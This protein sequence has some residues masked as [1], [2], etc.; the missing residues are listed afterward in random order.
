[1]LKPASELLTSLYAKIHPND[2]KDDVEFNFLKQRLI[3]WR[4]VI[5]K[6]FKNKLV[7]QFKSSFKNTMKLYRTNAIRG[8]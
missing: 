5:L 4:S 6:K 2:D 1:M 3:L 8:E 7:E